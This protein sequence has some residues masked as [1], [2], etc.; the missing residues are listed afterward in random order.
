MLKKLVLKPL[1]QQHKY[2]YNIQTE[3]PSFSESHHTLSNH[4][5]LLSGTGWGVPNPQWSPACDQSFSDY[6]ALR[7]ETKWLQKVIHLRSQGNN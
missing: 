2:I 3:L 4:T 6:A 7:L 5:A 1:T